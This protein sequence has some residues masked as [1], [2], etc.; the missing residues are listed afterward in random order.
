[1]TTAWQ[2]S[3]SADRF[4]AGKGHLP[5]ERAMWFFV[6]GDLIIFG[7]YFLM[8]MLDRTHQ[9]AMFLHGQQ[10]LNQAIGV[11]NTLV[12]LTSSWMVALATQ[13]CRAGKTT[14]SFRLF[15]AALVTGLLFPVLKLFEWIPKIAAGHTPGEN[16]FYQYY[17]MLTGLHLC[18]VLLGLVILVVVLRELR[19]ARQPRVEL[20]ETGATYWHMVDVLWLLLLALLYLMR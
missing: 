18:H 14:H 3:T 20:V 7:F 10:Q 2:Q 15:C 16:L 11:V 6:L 1:M 17:Y 9:P 13:A 8:Y 19:T 5:G 4:D 12:L